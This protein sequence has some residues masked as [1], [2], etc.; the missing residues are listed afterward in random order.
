MIKKG[1]VLTVLDTINNTSNTTYKVLAKIDNGESTTAYAKVLSELCIAKEILAYL[2]GNEIGIQIPEPCLLEMSKRLINQPSD[3]RILCFGSN[4]KN[5]SG[6]ERFLTSDKAFEE[7]ISSYNKTFDV[8]IFDEWLINIDR[9]YGNIL[10]DGGDI[11]FIDHEK[12]LDSDANV[13][14][15]ARTNSLF[16]IVQKKYKMLEIE[17]KIQ[18]YRDTLYLKLK[19]IELIPY[20]TECVEH[21]L[22]SDELGMFIVSQLSRRLPF[23]SIF[24][25]QR[26]C[27][28]QRTLGF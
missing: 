17:E 4:A 8:C 5:N 6:Y 27:M 22:I 21:L 16:D 3:E 19:E 1:Y 14:A 25:D 23:L 24:I 18:Y 11:W 12:I 10:I 15:L 28:N 2:V 20:I 9:N 13:E 26:F 7:F